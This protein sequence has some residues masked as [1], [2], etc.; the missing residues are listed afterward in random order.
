MKLPFVCSRLRPLPREYHAASR[1]LTR[2]SFLPLFRS[3]PAV[4]RLHATLC[5]CSLPSADIFGQG[6]RNSSYHGRCEGI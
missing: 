2:A 1:R 3:A 4:C 6:G 5:G